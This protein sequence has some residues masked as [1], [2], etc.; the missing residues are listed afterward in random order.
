MAPE[1]IG[2]VSVSLT[3]DLSDLKA[4]FDQAQTEAK[5][6]GDAVASAFTDAAEATNTFTDANGRLRDEFGRFVP[7]AQDAADATT[8]AG[9]ASVQASTETG[10]LTESMI[11]LGEALV[12]AEGLK[13]FA[14]EALDAADNVTRASI[15]LTT[16]T[17]SAESAATTIEGL[18]RLGIADGLSMPALLTAS[19]RMTALLPPGTDV[20][21]LLGKIADGAAVM[22]TS[23]DSAAN[24]FD[25]MAS[26]GTAG[27]RQLTALGLSLQS[28]AASMNAT[29]LATDATA[30]SASKLFKA[31]DET[32]RIT[33]LS[34]ALSAMGGVAEKVRD[35]TFGGQWASLMAQWDQLMV[36]AGQD[37]LPVVSGLVQLVSTDVLPFLREMAD[38]FKA[39]PAP[40]QEAVVGLGLALAA[41]TVL[42]LAVKG[43]G[44][45]LTP[46]AGIL[47]MVGVSSAGA[48]AAEEVEATAATA[49]AT[50]HE[51]LGASA[52]TASGEMGAA[53]IAAE[54]L[55]AILGGA[56]VLG[57]AAAVFGLIDLKT[58]LDAAHASIKTFSDADIN[59][60]LTSFLKQLNEGS[61]D[62]GLLAD[63]QKRVSD[64]MAAGIGNAQLEADVLKAIDQQTKLLTGSETGFTE[65][66]HLVTDATK[67]ATEAVKTA[68]GPLQGW[69]DKI[70]QASLVGSTHNNVLDNTSVAY[71]VLMGVAGVAISIL[72]NFNITV[73]GQ[74]TQLLTLQGRLDEATAKLNKIGAEADT[75]KNKFKD[76]EQAQRDVLKAQEDL[77]VYTAE[78]ATGLVGLTDKVSLYSVELA[79][80]TAKLTDLQNAY[81]SDPSLVGAVASAEDNLASIQQKLNTALAETAQ[82]G[83]AAAAGIAAAG[84]AAATAAS[85]IGSATAAMQAYFKSAGDDLGVPGGSV[86]SAHVSADDPQI[87]SQTI[88][89]VTH[90]LFGQGWSGGIFVG[91]KALGIYGPDNPPPS[92]TP[93]GGS[94]GGG[95]SSS[96]AAAAPSAAAPSTIG[97]VW[98]ID[99]AQ[100]G[101]LYTQLD[102]LTKLLGGSGAGSLNTA[103]IQGAVNAGAN[104][105]AAAAAVVNTAATSMTQATQTI[106]AVAGGMQTLGVAVAA[107]ATSVAAKAGVNVV[108][109]TT[110]LNQ[111]ASQVNAP[112]LGG[113]GG[114]NVVGSTTVFSFNF[115]GSNFGA[116][117][118]AAQM[119]DALAQALRTAGAR[120]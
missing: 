84:Q 56:L 60:S 72:D 32:D 108:G 1:D 10:S 90:I 47:D 92:N 116:S 78:M 95:S 112:I 111:A 6:A 4:T 65:Q 73:M 77:D 8:A 107:L 25:R 88:N 58:S 45:A 55:G 30:A 99:E 11:A 113:G 18:D 13:E 16:L 82:Q 69:I 75:T 70:N 64:A 43:L 104:T 26:S 54:G 61:V 97:G 93:A 46:I 24:M 31:L 51:G 71:K 23:I 118:T 14:T 87:T 22:G 68:T 28:L 120:F 19:T 66:I 40:I 105:T 3:G 17:G 86:A 53:G 96:G 83:P 34:N 76:L 100:N 110:T 15:A 85:E 37:I 57:I 67:L 50:A 114:T 2:G 62:A 119:Q 117:M 98:L 63:A 27:A 39:M 81:R 48:A 33:V 29:G 41:V 9:A 91:S 59:A 106:S 21:A 35:Q 44:L 101:T 103:G 49:A 74:N 5:Q 42:G 80:A 52:L 109:P 36:E 79:G 115:Q 38:D 7:M 12:V 20:V 89:G 102:T 94:S